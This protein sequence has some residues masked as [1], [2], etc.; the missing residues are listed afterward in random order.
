M[1]FLGDNAGTITARTAETA[2]FGVEDIGW[3]ALGP[4][5]ACTTLST[6]VVVLRWYTRCRLAR[7]LGLDDY[8]I[9]LSVVR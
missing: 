6:A 1:M 4:A 8:V 7:C 2:H 9:L 5:V 3:Q